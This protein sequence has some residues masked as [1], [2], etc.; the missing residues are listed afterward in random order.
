MRERRGACRVLVE[1]PE[2]R[3][4][5][6]KSRRRWEDKNVS[7]VSGMGLWAV[8]NWLR[9]GTGDEAVLDAVVKIRVPCREF[10]V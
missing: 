8:L 5:F 9:I 7:L 6:G 1:K 10:L 4:S 2:G 3:R